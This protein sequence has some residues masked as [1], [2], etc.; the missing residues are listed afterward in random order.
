MPEIIERRGGGEHDQN[1]LRRGIA[2]LS[3]L[4]VHESLSV[5]EVAGL[6][7]C[8]KSQASRVLKVL[9]EYG[10]VVRDRRTR[11][12]RVGWLVYGLALRMSGKD[13]VRLAGPV[14]RMLSRRLEEAC[15]L[16][17]LSGHEVL[18]VYT[19]RPRDGAF[20]ANELAGNVVPAYCTASGRALLSAYDDEELRELIGKIPIRPRGSK[21]PRT[22]DDVFTR[23]ADDRQRG[24]S[25]AE[26]ELED[27]LISVGVP[28]F[29]G[30]GHPAMSIGFS[31]PLDRVRPRLDTAVRE[32]LTASKHIT[33]RLLGECDHDPGSRPMQ[34]RG[35]Q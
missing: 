12:Y 11:R 18:A 35:R 9:A 32:V 25:I 26:D 16:A 13:M 20:M 1:T 29:D 21:S 33:S 7:S 30:A 3:F 22:L 31:A 4:A 8:D 24:Y 19:A 17:V 27:G 28:V 34:G 2:V 6:A 14:V 10:L 5:T 23:V 15:W